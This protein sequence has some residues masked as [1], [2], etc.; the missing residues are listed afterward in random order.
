MTEDEPTIV[1]R[2]YIEAMLAAK[3]KGLTGLRATSAVMAATAKVASRILQRQISIDEVQRL[4]ADN[5]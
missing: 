2:T 1:R 5:R 4:L 3:E